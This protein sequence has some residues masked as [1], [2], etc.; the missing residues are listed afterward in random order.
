MRNPT[1]L[2]AHALLGLTQEQFANVLGVKRQTYISWHFNGVPPKYCKTIELLTD[3][4]I[5]R[6]ELRP[7][8]WRLYWD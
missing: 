6:R 3:G 2:K 8:D 4:Q 1:L 5:N 7:D